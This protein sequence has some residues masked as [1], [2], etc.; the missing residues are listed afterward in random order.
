V[1]VI[2]RGGW[3][4]AP[5]ERVWEIVRRVEE[6]PSW[7]A[8]VRRAETGGPEGIGRLQRTYGSRAVSGVDVTASVIAYR[9][10]TLIAWRHVACRKGGGP[11]TPAR[12][13][14]LHIQLTPDGDQTR[15]QL[16][17]V[18]PAGPVTG[19]VCQITAVRLRRN[20]TRSLTA[21]THRAL[22]RS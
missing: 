11:W 4:A 10:P 17:A 14:E 22:T 21:L 16:Y 12:P 19:L 13:D 15:I 9:E 20:L 1:I 2:E 18:R 5:T 3:V 7:L 8:G 6:L